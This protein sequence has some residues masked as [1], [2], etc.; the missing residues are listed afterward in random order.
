[1]PNR[2]LPPLR[3]S[4][5][6]ARLREQDGRVLGHDDD[7]RSE[8]ERARRR[9]RPRQHD[10]R[11]DDIS[12]GAGYVA[13][14]LDR[15]RRLLRRPERVEP[16]LLGAWGEHGRVYGAVRGQYGD[17]DA[18]DRP[19]REFPR[20]YTRYEESGP[21][22]SPAFD[23]QLFRLDEA[24]GHESASTRLPARPPVRLFRSKLS[25]FVPFCLVSIWRV[26]HLAREMRHPVY[27]SPYPSPNTAA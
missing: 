18:Q 11:V 7:G 1:M 8:H 3:A 16:Q 4:R 2:S 22:A 27:R 20:W 5:V 24:N 14:R 9:R 15:Q 25:H 21:A 23:G 19:P 26:R 10:E 6:A 12:P 13:D 17:S